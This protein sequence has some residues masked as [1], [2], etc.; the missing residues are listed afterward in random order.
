MVGGFSEATRLGI[1]CITQKTMVDACD[2]FRYLM[3]DGL[4]HMIVW[5]SFQALASAPPV[6]HT[7]YHSEVGLSGRVIQEPIWLWVTI[8]QRLM[9]G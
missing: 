2:G 5:Q 6:V 7:L 9:G 4:Q 1:C 3:V 8:N